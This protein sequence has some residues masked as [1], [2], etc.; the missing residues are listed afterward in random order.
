MRCALGFVYKILIDLHIS[1]RTTHLNFLLAVQQCVSLGN[2]TLNC[3]DVHLDI[4][5]CVGKLMRITCVFNELSVQIQ[6]GQ[7]RER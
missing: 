1:G 4:E 5:I 7:K 6:H 2:C 3:V